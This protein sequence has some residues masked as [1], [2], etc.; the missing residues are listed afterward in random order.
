MRATVLLAE[1]DAVIREGIAEA[2][3]Q[4]Q[5]E[6]RSAASGTEALRVFLDEPADVVV[7]DV[8][9]PGMDGIALLD[10]VRAAQPDTIFIL[11]TAFGTI[12]SAVEAVKKGATTTSP[13]RSTWTA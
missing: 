9:M 8:K 7:A 3:R 1:D 2:L 6:V 13:S 10:Q 5:F 12:D 4:D 11:A